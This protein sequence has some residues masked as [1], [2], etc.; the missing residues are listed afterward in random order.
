MIA[1]NFSGSDGDFDVLCNMVSVFPVE[2][3]VVT[4]V[5]NVEE[6]YS[7]EYLA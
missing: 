1:Y 4:E 5:T 3:D 7:V 6:E 2:Y